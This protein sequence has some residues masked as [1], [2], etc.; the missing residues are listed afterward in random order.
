MGKLIPAVGIGMLGLC[1]GVLY[2]I[3]SFAAS[4][5][6]FDWT[7]IAEEQKSDDSG[8]DD[9]DELQSDRPGFGDCP[10]TVGCGRCQLEM[11]Y[12]YSYDHDS[13]ASHITHDYPESLLRIGMFENWFEARVSWSQEQDSDR[14]FGGARTTVVGSQDMNV[15]FKIA[16]TPQQGWLPKT[17]LVVDAFLPSGSSAFTSGKVLPEIEYIYEWQM[18]KNLQVDGITELARDADDVTNES[19][20]STSEAFGAEEKLT[21]N[22]SAYVQW[23]VT[24]PSG[25]NSVRTQQVI[26]GGLIVML[27]PN[28]QYDAEYGIGLNDA[29]PDYFVGT[30]LVVRR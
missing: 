28:V 11:G 17:G 3:R 22:L 29:T 23:H 6:L 5:T 30:G 13:T 16:L 27:T 19:F 15:G 24:S 4:D 1:F 14:V 20:L 21:E 7:R 26:E 25:A 8:G 12:Q 9:K 2:T 10:S 18:T